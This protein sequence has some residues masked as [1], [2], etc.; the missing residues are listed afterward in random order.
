[1]VGTILRRFPNT[2]LPDQDLVWTSNVIRGPE[3]LV[4]RLAP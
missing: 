3:E 1:M 4:V 2:T